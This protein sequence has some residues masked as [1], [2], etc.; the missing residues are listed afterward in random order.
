MNELKLT[1]FTPDEAEARTKKKILYLDLI[2]I[3]QS[4][5]MFLFYANR[6]NQNLKL[7]IDDMKLR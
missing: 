1:R 3:R 4:Y 7:L 2:L 5:D 6:K